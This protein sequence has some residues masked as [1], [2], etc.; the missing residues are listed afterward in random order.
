MSDS[1]E[2]LSTYE[3]YQE[4]LECVK[5]DIKELLKKKKKVN[6]E[7]VV[8]ANLVYGWE[9]FFSEDVIED[10]QNRMID[11]LKSENYLYS[12]LAKIIQKRFRGNK[13]RLES[14]AL[15]YLTKRQ[16]EQN[17]SAL[18]RNLQAAGWKPYEIQSFYDNDYLDERGDTPEMSRYAI[19][20]KFGLKK[21]KKKSKKS[22]KSKKKKPKK[23]KKKSKKT[24]KKWEYIPSA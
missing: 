24:N 20:E 6:Y 17:W 15:G 14:K 1:D 8:K 7:K 22:K 12:E 19:R 23:T 10:L 13:S 16:K 3:L 4:A 18:K 11:E 5:S 9:G 2:E 21:K